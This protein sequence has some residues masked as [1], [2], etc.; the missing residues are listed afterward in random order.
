[1]QV[2]AH[3]VA[4][5]VLHHREAMGFHVI[6]NSTG[7][8]QQG[9]AGLDL[10]QALHQRFLGHPAE[11]LGLLAGPLTHTQAHAAIAVVAIE[12]GPGIDLHQVAGLDHPLV[13]GDAVH[14]LVVD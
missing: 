13:A 5:V 3:A 6:L 10:G 4:R 14:H 7:D 8:I 9:V 12:I 1:M 2:A 11:G